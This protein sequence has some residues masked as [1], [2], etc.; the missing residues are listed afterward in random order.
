MMIGAAGFVYSPPRHQRTFS[1]VMPGG[2]VR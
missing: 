1:K 2:M